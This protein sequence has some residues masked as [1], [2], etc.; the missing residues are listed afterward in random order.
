[1]HSEEEYQ[2]LSSVAA[3]ADLTFSIPFRGSFEWLI[4]TLQSLLNQTSPN[5]VAIVADNSDYGI[6]ANSHEVFRDPRIKIL[7]SSGN[8][9]ASHNGLV[10]FENIVTRWGVLLG[11]DDLMSPDFVE[12]FESHKDSFDDCA[13]LVPYFSTI[14]EYGKPKQYMRDRINRFFYPPGDFRHFSQLYMLISLTMSNWLYF[15]GIIFNM[16]K[17]NNVCSLRIGFDNTNDLYFCFDL[18]LKNQQ[19]TFVKDLRYFYRR[20]RQ[21]ISLN[22]SLALSRAKE[23]SIMFQ[24]INRDLS[25]AEFPTGRRILIRTFIVLHLGYRLRTI[26]DAFLAKSNKILLLKI[27]LYR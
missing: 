13:A 16:S 25:L 11:A 27:A 14:D 21:S 17:V 9:S 20:S 23:E 19:F 12:V 7:R 3:R 18:L 1:M 8:L 2:P 4:E 6:D 5:W 26:Y 15:T 22:P 24:N 10:A